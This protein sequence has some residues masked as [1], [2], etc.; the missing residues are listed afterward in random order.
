MYIVVTNKK[1]EGS[2]DR[3]KNTVVTVDGENYDRA[4]PAIAIKHGQRFQAM[5][6]Y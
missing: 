2:L 1:V 5:V 3:I 4:T 6:R